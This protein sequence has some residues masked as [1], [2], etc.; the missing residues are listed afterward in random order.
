ML[1]NKLIFLGVLTLSIASCGGGGGGGDDSDNGG[2]SVDS[3]SDAGGLA[4]AC[5]V[6]TNGSN[7]NPVDTSRGEE[8]TV[9]SVQDS[10]VVMVNRGGEQ[11]LVKLQSLGGTTGF[12]NTG[13]KDFLAN[14]AAAEKVFMFETGCTATV[15]NAQTATVVHLVT[16]S[17]RSFAEEI[18]KEHLGGVL[19]TTGTC[20]EDQ[21]ASCYQG[22]VDANPKHT[23]G[24]IACS[25]SVPGNVQYSPA[26]ASCGGNAS[27]TVSGDLEGA[28]SIQLRYPDGTD[29]LVEACESADC[30][31]YKVQ[32]YQHPTDAKVGCF[33][34][35]GN[36]IA[37]SDV[38]HTSIKRDANDHD[39][40]RYCIPDP[41]VAIN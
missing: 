37:L 18:M 4:T 24:A 2:G 7:R 23:A 40:L 11:I 12:N 36:S 14:L 30:T 19:E 34:A 9:V 8:V 3:G 20:G 29:R 15:L 17:G 16:A 21:L 1:K 35:P 33:G 31:P 39:P 32:D 28:F 6:I 13:A 25:S 26:N 5:G 27:V 41:A 10:N 22:I 38:A